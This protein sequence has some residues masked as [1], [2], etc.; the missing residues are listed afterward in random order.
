[1]NL[2]RVRAKA[3]ENGLI[4]PGAA[5]S[6]KELLQLI[7][8]PGFSTAGKIT[9]L[10]GRGVGMDVVKRAVEGLHGTIEMSSTPGQGSR[11]GLRIPITLAIID[12]LL[13]RVGCGRY[14]IPLYAVEECLELPAEQDSR[15]TGRSLI[16]LR[17]RIVPFVRLRELFA[18]GG[19]PAPYQKM[20]VISTGMEQIG[21]VVDSILGD[22][23]TVIKSLSRFHASIGAYSG[24][25]ILGDGSVALVLDVAYLA[26][27]GQ[28]NTERRRAG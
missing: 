7:F 22:H 23:Q 20:V 19:E 1:V 2:E 13:V 17:G 3:E 21:L 12:G 24:A 28:A 16:T 26:A 18:I 25:T 6:E 9:G 14:V 15:I 4:T 10:S 27:A 11:I 8:Q 5:P